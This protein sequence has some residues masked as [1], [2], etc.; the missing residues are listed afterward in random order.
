[1]TAGDVGAVP[2]RRTAWATLA[3]TVV[4]G[5][6]VLL[7]TTLTD[8]PGPRWPTW[9]WVSFALF[10]SVQL[11]T[12][13]FLPRPRTLPPRFW[14][15]AMVVLALMTFLQYPD[16]GLTAALLVV[17]AAAVARHSSRRALVLVVILQ[18][19]LAAAA[20]RVV[21]APLVDV[22]AGLVAFGGFQA[23]G[24]LVVLAARGETEARQELAEAHTELGA[25]VALLEVAT[26]DAERLRIARDL[27]DVVGHQLTALTL[28]L[29]VAAH[30]LARITEET[31]STEH[32]TRAR[33]IAKDLLGDVRAAIGEM[34]E[35]EG[36][37]E[38]KL[39]A[40][41]RRAPGLEVCVHLVDSD[42]IEAREASVVVRCVQEAITN[43]LR[44]A[45]AERLELTVEAG[46]DEIRVCARD[47]GDGAEAVVPGN[48]LI[49]MRERLEA[50]GGT[51]D[52]TSSPGEGFALV[53]SLPRSGSRIQ[54]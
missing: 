48:G 26:R 45:R 37:L 10:L 16:H 44:H 54:A 7:E 5:V 27:H 8:L 46:R 32:V 14:V 2:G 28:E 52:V 35:P 6:V 38:S 25:T 30:Q 23:F 51:L 50:L 29:E 33:T 4:A 47:D 11:V 41:A 36:G 53:G 19:A 15:S 18:T 20:L 49:G 12:T 13:G 1:M 3:C 31:P 42:M 39:R 34:R 22:I 24:A 9:W 40:L 17:S 43:T 21:G